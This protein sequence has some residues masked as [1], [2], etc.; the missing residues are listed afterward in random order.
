M[1]PGLRGDLAGCT[2]KAAVRSAPMLYGRDLERS[3][4][5][6]L[7][8]GARASESAVLVISGEPGVG[9]SAL[10][11]DAREQAGGMRRAQRRGGGI[12]DAASVRRP[13]PARPPGPSHIWRRFRTRRPPPSAERS[14]LATG[15]SGD[16][17]LVSLATLSLLA[18]AAE[19]QPILCLDRRCAVARRRD[20]GCASLRRQAARGRGHRHALR[21]AG[22]RASTLRG[23]RAPRTASWRARPGDGRRADRSPRAR[24]ALVGGPRPAGRG[25]RRKPTR[26]ARAVVVPERGA[27]FGRR[28]NAHTNSGRS[29]GGA[30]LSRARAAVAG[31]DADAPARRCRRRQR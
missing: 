5:G 29:P 1:S 11:A 12:G 26:P 23:T 22:G 8:A 15:G 17:F 30:G 13:A 14:A 31:G 24:R 3:R 16:R 10:L 19:R 2:G 25:H 28:G 18:E 7:L 21:R 4:I 27:A 6:E 9:K 20:R